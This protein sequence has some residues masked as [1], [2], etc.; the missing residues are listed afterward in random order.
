MIAIKHGLLW[1]NWI[2]HWGTLRRSDDFNLL[3]RCI[4]STSPEIAKK[5]ENDEKEHNSPNC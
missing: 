2:I 5:G 3:R 1:W 4:R